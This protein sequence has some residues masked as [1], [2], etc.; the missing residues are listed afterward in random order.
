MKKIFSIFKTI[1]KEKKT[2]SVNESP[3]FFTENAIAKINEHIESRPVGIK[4]AFK[5]QIVYEKEK[6]Q[7]QV[8]FD[9]YKLIRKTLYEYP[10]PVILNEKD[11]LFLRGAYID[12]HLENDAFFYYPNIHL[13]VLSRFKNSILV[14]YLDR[15]IV[16]PK[17]QIQSIAIQQTS[18]PNKMPLLIRKLFE[19]DL[20]ESIYAERNFISVEKKVSNQTD[21]E[22]E[23]KITDVILSYY[24]TCGYPLWVSDHNI[25]AY[26]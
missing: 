22:V 15:N 11:E 7:C 18:L 2:L 9:D 19:T 14:F 24:E 26:F 8:G 5:I 6:I 16:S 4:S 3:L 21:L 25:E 1:F 10:V 13:E 23:E 12:Y 17:S 20:V